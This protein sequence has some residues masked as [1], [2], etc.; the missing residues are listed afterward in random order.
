[1]DEMDKKD[2]RY[3]CKQK[4]KHNIEYDHLVNQ[5]PYDIESIDEIVVLMV[6][7]VCSNREYLA[8]ILSMAAFTITV[9]AN[10]PTASPAAKTEEKKSVNDS[11]QSKS[12]LT[13]KGNLTAVDDVHQVTDTSKN[14][15]QDKEFLTVE[16][17]NG[18]TFYI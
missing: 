1:M 16:S 2:D 13:P 15:V 12:P 18:N 14:T 17:K 4:I 9:S 5:Y 8:V 6:D 10:T 7:T 3:I 11:S